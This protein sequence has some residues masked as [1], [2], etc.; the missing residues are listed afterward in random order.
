[1]SKYTPLQQHFSS[2]RQNT[3]V[4]SFTEIEAIIGLPLPRSA[5]VHRE[6]W[7]NHIHNT[8]GSAWLKS[9]WKVQEVRCIDQVVIFERLLKPVEQVLSRKFTSSPNEWPASL[10]Q[11]NPIYHQYALKMQW[12]RLGKIVIDSANRLAFPHANHVAGVYRFCIIHN[13]KEVTYIG[14]TGNLNRRFAGYRNPGRNQQTNI[15]LNTILIQ[16]LKN[17]AE[18]AVFIM[19]ENALMEKGGISQIADFTSKNIRT[20]FESAAIAS[21]NES[22]LLNRYK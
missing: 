5:L 16:T 2:L 10:P 8:Q 9:R 7:A 18:I 3:W 17:G 12:Q 13:N 15:R 20:L 21:F 14:E 6:W 1:M 11:D 22:E 19:D 4:A